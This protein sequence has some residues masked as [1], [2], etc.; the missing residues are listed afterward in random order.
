[1]LAITA[2]SIVK[3]R[4]LIDHNL[5]FIIRSHPWISLILM[6]FS[7]LLT[8]LWLWFSRCLSSCLLTIYLLPWFM[9]V[10]CLLLGSVDVL[11]DGSWWRRSFRLRSNICLCIVIEVLLA[12]VLLSAVVLVIVIACPSIIIVIF[13]IVIVL[14]V[15]INGL[16]ISII[17]SSIILIMPRVPSLLLLLIIILLLLGPL[18]ISRWGR[19][20][21]LLSLIAA[22]RLVRGLYFFLLGQWLHQGDFSRIPSIF[23]LRFSLLRVVLLCLF[24][25]LL[26]L[27]LV[28]LLWSI[29]LLRLS[30]LVSLLMR[31]WLICFIPVVVVVCWSLLSIVIFIV[32]GVLIVSTTSSAAWVLL[33]FVGTTVV[34]A[35]ISGWTLLACVLWLVGVLPHLLILVLLL[36]C[37]ARGL[38]SSSTALLLISLIHL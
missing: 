23:W 18:T 19:L 30:F 22:F 37:M 24:L 28:L 1:M 14:V 32:V 12:I 36:T 35:V 17:T 16:R 11:H 38:W 20:V 26:R 9:I 15:R 8:P 5:V 25:L 33:L 7:L 29:L 10:A 34:V 4:D 3:V 27:T 31:L 2:L 21:V 13:S 6:P